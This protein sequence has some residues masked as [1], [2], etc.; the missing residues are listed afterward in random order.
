MNRIDN[1]SRFVLFAAGLFVLASSL[2]GC[3]E[4]NPNRLQGY[5]EGEFIY[6]AAPSAG[7]LQSLYVRRGSQ[8]K[9]GEC[10]FALDSTPEKAAR[11]EAE[12]KLAAARASWQDA[13]KGKR[14][15][16]I[17]SLNAQLQQA[18]SALA[19]SERNLARREKLL[20]EGGAS[21][22]DR[23]RAKFL[24]DQDR[25]RVAQLQADLETARLGARSDQIAAAAANVRAL[26]SA[27]IKAEWDL[28][29]KQPRVRKSA[30]VYDTLYREGEWVPAGR[31]VVVLLPPENIKVRA[32]VPETRIGS[33]QIGQKTRVRLD[34]M[35]DPLIGK[36]AFISPRAEYTPPVI[37]SRES[38][39]KLV[40]LI[41]LRFELATAVRLHP[42]QPVDVDV[43]P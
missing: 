16:E 32:F 34:G 25:Q 17:D 4:G 7:T 28:S 5:A 19:L 9:A 37:Y 14:P 43:G 33:V 20:P 3:D 1:P 11:D 22:E 41:E 12:R 15:S 38:R 39:G 36:V 21:E 18:Q 40:F 26:E 42:G 30:L 2:I 8:V 29:Q 24:R 31:P 23:D 6:V 35:A 10:L 13:K 27:L